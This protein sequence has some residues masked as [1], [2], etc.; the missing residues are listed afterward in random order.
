MFEAVDLVVK[1]AELTTEASKKFLEAPALTF[2]AVDL[3][4][5]AAKLTTEAAQKF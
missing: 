1:A 5:K 4:V 3:V 2:E